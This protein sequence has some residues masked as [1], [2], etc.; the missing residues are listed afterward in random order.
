M[1]ARRPVAARRADADEQ[2]KLGRF[3]TD[4]GA[5]ARASD[6]LRRR[7]ALGRGQTYLGRG[8]R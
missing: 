1:A 5:L 2:A 6:G 3:D 7:K 4:L 8:D